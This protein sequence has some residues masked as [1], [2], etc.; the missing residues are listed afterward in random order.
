MS[1]PLNKA[2]LSQ[3][4]FGCG[5]Y[6]SMMGFARYMQL[7]FGVQFAREIHS[8]YESILSK[9]DKTYIDETRI[10]IFNDIISI[11]E[12][13]EPENINEN[14][15]QYS[16]LSTINLNASWIQINKNVNNKPNIMDK[17]IQYKT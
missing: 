12:V 10:L 13:K 16:H 14:D 4:Y 8:S 6:C 2:T 1:P 5:Y 9:N 11:S 17:K 7:P 15:K 3:Q